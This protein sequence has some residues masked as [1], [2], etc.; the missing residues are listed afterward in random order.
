MLELAHKV[1]TVIGSSSNIIQKPLEEIYSKN[2]GDINKR[3]PDLTKLRKYTNYKISKDLE[4]IIRD[5]A[6]D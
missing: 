1:K 2:S 4:T 5:I 3:I 6:N